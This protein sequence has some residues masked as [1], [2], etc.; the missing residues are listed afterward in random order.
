M[1]ALGKR[2]FVITQ[3]TTGVIVVTS[4]VLIST[5]AS[6]RSGNPV[7]SQSSV[8]PHSSNLPLFFMQPPEFPLGVPGHPFHAT[9]TADWSLSVPGGKTFDTEGRGNV[10][11]DA[12]GDM[13]VEGAMARSGRS[14]NQHP[15]FNVL[16]LA[17]D[18][19]MLSWKSGTTNVTSFRAANLNDSNHFFESLT[20]PGAFGLFRHSLYNCRASG[21]TCQTVPLGEKVI[22][23]IHA[24]GTRYQD[25]VPAASLG[26]ANDVL[27][28][29][30]VWIDS[31]MNAVILIECEDPLS[32]DFTMRLLSLSE[33]NQNKD[34]FEIPK[35]YRV[36]DITPPAGLPG[37]P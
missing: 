31:E 12:A 13:R 22:N 14:L 26:A 7:A 28:T 18:G 15:A 8:A 16:F 17:A 37:H 20:V 3:S 9:V 21:V 23:G 11:R 27:F 19:T 10:W 29:R 36:N 34:L 32:G 1:I 33:G 4:L 6:C 35:G 30:D 5:L 25:L 24:T 2:L